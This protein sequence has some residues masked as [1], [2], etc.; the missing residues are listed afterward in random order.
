MA[1]WEIWDRLSEVA[2]DYD[3]TL[4]IRPTNELQED[5]DKNQEVLIGDDD[6]DTVITISSAS[7]YYVDLMVENAEE[8]DAGTILDLYHDPTKANGRARSFRWIHYGEKSDRHTYTVK[9]AD[10]PR[11]VVVPPHNY[12]VKNIRLKIIGRAPA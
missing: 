1:N 5:G 2:P 8:E 10:R 11:R 4:D 3:Y 9:F 6:S 12:T 7:I